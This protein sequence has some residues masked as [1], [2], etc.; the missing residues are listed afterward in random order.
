MVSADLEHPRRFHGAPS[1]SISA[2]TGYSAGSDVSFVDDTVLDPF[3]GTGTTML[4]ALKY[5]RNSIGVEIDPEYCRMV[6]GHL[7]SGKGFFQ[8]RRV[9]FRESRNGQERL[10]GQG[11]RR[12]LRRESI[13][14]ESGLSLSI[15]GRRHSSCSQAPNLLA[16]T[17]Q[18][19]YSRETQRPL[20]HSLGVCPRA[21]GETR[22][23]PRTNLP[24]AGSATT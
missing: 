2:R 11:R 18:S 10:A 8:Q 13:P 14:P 5:E 23:L 17:P 12:A 6:A 24:T 15:E 1:C 19:L 20:R 3:C 9:G 22:C 4:A 21:E 16:A 7:K